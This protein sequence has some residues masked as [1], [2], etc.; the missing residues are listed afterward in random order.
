MVCH[1]N[2]GPRISKKD[3]FETFS[4]ITDKKGSFKFEK[5]ND[6]N[7]SIDNLYYHSD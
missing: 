5:K 4:E 6:E 3:V 7:N 1:V 2:L